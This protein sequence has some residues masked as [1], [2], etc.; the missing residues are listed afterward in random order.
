[1]NELTLTVGVIL[2]FLCG[3]YG[4]TKVAGRWLRR[5]QGSQVVW[6]AKMKTLSLVRKIPLG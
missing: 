5:L 6:C 1:M 3:W 2:F 4:M